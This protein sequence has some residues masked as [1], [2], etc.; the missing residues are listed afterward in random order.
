MPW[1]GLYGTLAWTPDFGF[2]RKTVSS[3]GNGK[4]FDPLPS[5][6]AIFVGN[7][8]FF[9]PLPTLAPV[10]SF[11][12]T[13]PPAVFLGPGAILALSL[14]RF[15]SGGGRRALRLAPRTAGREETAHPDLRTRAGRK[16][17]E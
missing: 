3:A 10:F 5:N 17:P 4:N 2:S 11:F 7:G 8:P 12:G 1:S 15:S 16:P 14:R 13:A 9:D 6:L